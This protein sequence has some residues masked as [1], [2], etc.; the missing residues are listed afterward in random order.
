M[1][2]PDPTGCGYPNRKSEGPPLKGPIAQMSTDNHESTRMQDSKTPS[3]RVNG[4]PARDYAWCRGC[5]GWQ[6][7]GNGRPRGWYSLSVR[8]PAELG[9]NGRPYVWVGEW[10]SAACLAG[11]MADLETAE[12]RARLAYEA[13]M[14]IGRE[15]AS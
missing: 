3:V 2:Q 6:Y 4:R 8:V 15:A 14:P 11:S 9:K 13:D 10:C 5:N 1:G 12:L 7:N